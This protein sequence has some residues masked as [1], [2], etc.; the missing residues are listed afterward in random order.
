MKAVIRKGKN[1][2][3]EVE[4]SQWCN[5][6][7]STTDGRI[8]SPTNLAFTPED[9]QEIAKDKGSGM[10]FGWFETTDNIAGF[11]K[12]FCGFKKRKPNL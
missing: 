9:I 8:L 1:K 7:F 4:I 6:W 11:G 12:Y 2:G 5:D 3:Q 10:M